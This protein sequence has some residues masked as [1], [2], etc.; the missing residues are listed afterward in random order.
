MNGILCKVGKENEE[1]EQKN[2]HSARIIVKS[3][4]NTSRCQI[5]FLFF[6]KFWGLNVLTNEAII[7]R[8]KFLAD[9]YTTGILVYLCL[10]NNARISNLSTYLPLSEYF[11]AFDSFSP[12]ITDL[13]MART[14]SLA[15]I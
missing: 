4:G 1:S 10:N 3:E 8:H 2:W 12:R 15:M 14:D 13:P 6:K 5:D 11:L 7:F 9:P